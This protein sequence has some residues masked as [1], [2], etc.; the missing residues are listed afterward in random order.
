MRDTCNLL[1]DG[2][3][4][5]L[6]ALAAVEGSDVKGW[7]KAQGYERY[8]VLQRR[9]NWRG[10]SCEEIG[11]ATAPLR[12]FHACCFVAGQEPSVILFSNPSL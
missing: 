3:V 2:I 7:A 1:A 10:D 9:I 5:L 12:S 11:P 4:K 8:L 6:R